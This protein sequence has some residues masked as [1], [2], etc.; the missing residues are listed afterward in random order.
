MTKRKSHILLLFLLFM[1]IATTTSCLDLP[2]SFDSMREE[3]AITN[4]SYEETI[5]DKGEFWITYID[6]GQADAALV[7]CDGHYML[8]DGGNKEDSN[9]IYSILERHGVESL[10]IVVGTHAHED[11]IGGIPGAFAFITADLTLCPVTTYDSNAF[12]DFAQAAQDKGGGIT[13][14]SAGDTFTL[15]SASVTILGLNF[16][17]EELNDTSI[18]LRIDYGETSFLFT[19]DAERAAETALLES[20]A[21]LAATVLKIG[22]HGAAASTTY[23]FLRAV[24][25]QIAIISVG[26]D[27][28]YGHPT[29]EAL[30][31]LMDADVEIYRTDLC[32][33]ITVTSDGIS[34]TV[35]AGGEQID[36]DSEP[37]NTPLYILN[38]NTHVFHNPTCESAEQILPQN[39][40]ESHSSRDELM[41]QGY[42][43]CGACNP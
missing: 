3:S 36:S 28:S 32:G 23:P 21:D 10:D 42:R 8:I 29:E 20:G 4:S 5:T 7:Y 24:S 27:N 33:D 38:I 25:P 22:H 12:Q 26:A 17:S 19:G 39:R 37:S 18:V 41:E 14:P 16:E 1:L 2:V 34:V 6:V 30:S 15:G 35:T 31:R 11:H 43:P 40:I 9:R 13:V